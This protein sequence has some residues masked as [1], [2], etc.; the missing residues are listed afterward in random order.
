MKE[1]SKLNKNK[2]LK[3]PDTQDF[4]SLNKEIKSGVHQKFIDNKFLGCNILCLSSACE[5][6]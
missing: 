5:L 1:Y 2:Q 6:L 4:I 3:I